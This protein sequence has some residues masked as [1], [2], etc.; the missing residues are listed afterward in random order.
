MN[1]GFF[2]L[3]KK[4]QRAFLVLLC[5]SVLGVLAIIPYT[6]SVI[7]PLQEIPSIPALIIKNILKG[8][9]FFALLAYLG[10]LLKRGIPVAGLPFLEE[11]KPMTLNSIFKFGIM[12]GVLGFI[13]IVGLGSLWAQTQQTPP[14]IHSGEAFYGFLASFYGG[15]DEEVISRFFT[16]GLLVFLFKKFSNFGLWLSVILAAL[17][18]GAGHLPAAVKALNL[19]SISQIPLAVTS[20]IILP[21]SIFGVIAGWLYW[22]KGLEYS[23][24]AHF[25]ADLGLHVL[26]PLLRS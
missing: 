16:M 5:F 20:Q 13:L 25:I 24:I 8:S 22:K 12:P 18:F 10:F 14:A 17:L 9:V 19:H 23:M 26:Y 7:M 15:I 2:K 6:L 3:C 1:L 11:G 4:E 21:N